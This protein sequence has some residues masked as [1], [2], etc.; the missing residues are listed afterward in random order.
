MKRANLLPPLLI[1]KLSRSRPPIGTSCAS[2]VSFYDQLGTAQFPTGETRDR[3]LSVNPARFS[4]G[5][6]SIA[7]QPCSPKISCCASASFLVILDRWPNQRHVCTR[8]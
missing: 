3:V 6:P 1:G 4:L 5:I 7:D 8:K 2:V